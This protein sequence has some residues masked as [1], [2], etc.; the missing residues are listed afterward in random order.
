M[1]GLIGDIFGTIGYSNSLNTKKIDQ[2][3]DLLKQQDWF[4][5]IYR[6]EKYHRLFFA[7]KHVRGYLQSTTRVKKIIRNREAQTKL[8]NFLDKQLKL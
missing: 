7:N 1:F 5:E 4:E 8:L 6:D 2:N 3:I